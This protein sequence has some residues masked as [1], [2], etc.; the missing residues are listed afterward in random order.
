MT[1]ASGERGRAAGVTRLAPSPTGALH[2]GNARTFLVNW[3]LARRLG[4]RIVMR[5]ED[6]D[7]P[8]VKP[9]AIEGVVR[10][11]EWL[12][13]EWDEGPVVQ[14]RDVGPY[15]EA[16][17]SLAGRGLVYPCDLTRTQI[18]EGLWSTAAGGGAEAGGGNA[19]EMA[20]EA[21]SA[22]QEGSR[23]VVFPASLRPELRARAFDR[24]DVN[25]RLVVKPGVVEVAD[26]FA[27]VRRFDP[28]ETIGDFVVWTKRGQPSY[29]LAV[30]VDDHRQGVTAVVRGDDLLDSAARQRRV[31][32]ALQIGPVPEY[33]HLPLVRGGDG[34][35]LAKRHGDTRIDSYR[36]R[37]V[38]AERII[39][40]A[41]WWSGMREAGEAGPR[42]MTA[43]EF[44]DKFD[45]TTMDR[46]SREA[47]VFGPEEERWL[48][49]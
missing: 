15:R 27:G 9:E 31:Y 13:L 37:G 8:R 26:R 40:L 22:P 3:A 14:S 47:V 5:I 16:M 43:A 7:G 48:T 35:R 10:T 1:M 33:W 28:A 42:A 44:R 25:W 38:G 18:E 32:E 49:A 46:M 19:E 34:R 41:A 12:G 30:V 4:W 20:A 45:L 29:Q 39:G 36:A 2:L 11:L 23:E 17:R 21:A 6:L 24:D